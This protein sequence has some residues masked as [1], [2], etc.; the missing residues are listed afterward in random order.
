MRYDARVAWLL[1]LSLVCGAFAVTGYPAVAGGLV[2]PSF[3]SI[4]RLLFKIRKSHDEIKYALEDDED[5]DIDP[6]PPE[7]IS[8]KKIYITVL[9][10]IFICVGTAPLLFIRPYRFI[11]I[12]STLPLA[13]AA[14]APL[15]FVVAA[16][17]KP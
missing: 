14:I 7:L 3:I 17:I 10:H 6:N 15:I 4:V 5:F 16:H 2:L 11:E 9:G 8:K 12:P 1:S 13:V